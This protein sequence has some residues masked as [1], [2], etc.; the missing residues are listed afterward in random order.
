[1]IP[2]FIKNV[3]SMRNCDRTSVNSAVRG[4]SD[5]SRGGLDRG[6]GVRKNSADIVYSKARRNSSLGHRQLLAWR[7]SFRFR[8]ANESLNFLRHFLRLLQHWKMANG[9]YADCA[10]PGMFGCERLLRLPVHGVGGLRVNMNC[11][12]RRIEFLQRKQG[13]AMFRISGGDFSSGARP[14]FESA[15]PHFVLHEIFDCFIADAL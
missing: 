8:R 4:T 10:E 14:H 15:D 2:V 7:S 6:Q 9:I 1:M 12:Y 13:I 11:R 5:D 3:S